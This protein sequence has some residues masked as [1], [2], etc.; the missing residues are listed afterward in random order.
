MSSAQANN[1]KGK[2]AVGMT[3]KKQKQRRKAQSNPCKT[4]RR[5]S[6]KVFLHK[7]TVCE[8]NGKKNAAQ[9]ANRNGGKSLVSMGIK[10]MMQQNDVNKGKGVSDCDGSPARPRTRII[11]VWTRCDRP[12]ETWSRSSPA[13]YWW[14][15]GWSSWESTCAEAWTSGMQDHWA[16][17]R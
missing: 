7:S 2:R 14:V 16:R 5:D 6:E 12:F 9:G 11:P 3:K 15:D 17:G 4:T 13:Q 10:V 1:H 8:R